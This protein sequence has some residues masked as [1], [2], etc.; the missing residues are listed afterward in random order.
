MFEESSM[1]Q[2]IKILKE[3]F[4]HLTTEEIK[5]RLIKASLSPI[6]QKIQLLRALGADQEETDE[7]FMGLLVTYMKL[8]SDAP[9]L[10]GNK[11]AQSNLQ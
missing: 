2:L 7:Y 6:Y 3:T 9:Q 10:K 8:P 4:P 11:D 1:E 5:H